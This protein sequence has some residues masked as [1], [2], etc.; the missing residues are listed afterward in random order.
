MSDAED[1][2]RVATAMSAS[3]DLGERLIGWSGRWSIM[4]NLAVCH[5]CLASQSA[6]QAWKPFTHMD[7]CIAISGKLYPWRELAE[8]LGNLPPML[9]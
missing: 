3:H 2:Y 9:N 7:G 8:I 1:V 4:G 5:T 6:D